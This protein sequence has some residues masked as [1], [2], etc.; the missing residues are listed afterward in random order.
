M[1]PIIYRAILQKEISPRL[2]SDFNRFQKVT[3]CWRKENGG[4]ILK[5]I[6]FTEQWGEKEYEIL[7]DCLKNTIDNGG[8]VF[9]AFSNGRLKGFCSVENKP[10]GSRKQYLQLSSLH[11]S[12]DMRRKG[13]GNQLF[14]LACK[15]AGELGA[16]KL[17]ISSHSAKET[18]AFYHALGCREAQ[19]YNPVL[20]EA[21][22][23]DCQLEYILT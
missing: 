14:Q 10:F 2:F 18:Q 16:E 23:C 12:S 6:S 9:G 7:C 3:Q 8:G 19:E 20:A 15:K 17:Y 1:E 22:P 4:W 21:E 13:A 5:D 11:V